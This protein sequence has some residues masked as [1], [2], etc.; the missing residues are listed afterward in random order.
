[1]V[2]NV[3]EVGQFRV[4]GAVHEV[5]QHLVGRAV[6]GALEF[7]GGRGSRE[8][9][10]VL[11]NLEVHEIE[12]VREAVQVHVFV[13][14]LELEKDREGH[15]KGLEDRVESVLLSAIDLLAVVPVQFDF[16][17]DSRMLPMDFVQKIVDFEAIVVLN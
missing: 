10:E 2:E 1:M 12:A 14:D 17:I 6:E 3:P 15:Q 4:V 13:K 7:G 8:V 9:L 5:E 16:A 11:V